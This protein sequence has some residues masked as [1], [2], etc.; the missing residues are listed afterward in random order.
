MYTLPSYPSHYRFSHNKTVCLSTIHYGIKRIGTFSFILSE[1]QNMWLNI[2]MINDKYKYLGHR[3]RKLKLERNLIT[4][5]LI[6]IYSD[7]KQMKQS[8][9]R[10]L[11]QLDMRL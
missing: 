1:D 2:L 8:S 3:I 7:A 9:I 5:A 11:T 4:K 6:K 10:K